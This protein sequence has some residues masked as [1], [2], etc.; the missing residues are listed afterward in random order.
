M[1]D[2]IRSEWT[3]ARSTRATAWTLP[4][5]FVVAVLLGYLLSLSLSGS[6]QMT[7]DWDALD[8]R[9]ATLLSVTLA[10]LVLIVFGVLSMGGEY[11]TG[12]IRASLTVVPGRGRFYLGK[13]IAVGAMAACVAA[14][15]VAAAF[16]SAGFGLGEYAVSLGEAEMLPALLGAWA[17]LTMICLFAVGL[18]ALLRSSI[19]TLAIL[20][21]V[22]FL[23]S[24]GLGNV[25]GIKDYAQYL[26]SQAGMSMMRLVPADD[27]RFSHP[28]GPW[29]AVGILAIWLAAALIGGYVMTRRRDA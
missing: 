23:D 9:F 24:Q 25:P 6:E 11:S 12:S 27:S 26:P 22:L 2:V 5:T 8:A 10:Q 19:F 29:G 20:L 28:Y 16:V 21:P 13:V 7:A 15:T 14:V 4:L 1:F 17:Y 18:T 3:K